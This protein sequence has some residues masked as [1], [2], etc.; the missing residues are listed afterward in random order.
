MGN[1]GVGIAEN[2]Y[3]NTG[4]LNMLCV[5]GE[6]SVPTVGLCEIS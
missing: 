5:P 1:C 6:R 4:S 2:D 3:G